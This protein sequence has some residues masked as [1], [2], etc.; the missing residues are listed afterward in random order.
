MSTL[1]VNIPRFYC[2]LRR[3][4]LY[5]DLAHKGEF[6]KVCVFGAASVHGRALGFHVLTDNGAVIGDCRCTLC[7]TRPKPQ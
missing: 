2:L 7:V 3:E 4:F 6:V 5:D 1:N